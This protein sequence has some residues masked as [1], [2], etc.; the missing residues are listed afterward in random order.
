MKNFLMCVGLGEMS[1]Y[2]KSGGKRPGGETS[3]GKCSSPKST[4]H[5]A[6]NAAIVNARASESLAN[7]KSLEAPTCTCC[8][9]GP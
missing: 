4:M 9:C 5:Y 2:A 3:G 7:P 6:I 8:R 1:G